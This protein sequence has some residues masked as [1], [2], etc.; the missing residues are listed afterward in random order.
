MPRDT[1]VPKIPLEEGPPLEV[2]RRILAIWFP[3]L[4]TDR[5]HRRLRAAAKSNQQD[6][7]NGA[8][9]PTNL[10]L[11]VSESGR[12]LVSAMDR[13]AAAEGIRLDMPLTDARALVPDIT[14]LPADLQ[15]DTRALAGLADWA[16]RYTPWA[17]PA[18][19][20]G[21][22]LD[23]SGCAHLFGG[24]MALCRDAAARLSGFGYGAR[25]AV[26]DTPGAAW[27]IARSGPAHVAGY[28]VAGYDVAG[29]EGGDDRGIL[30]PGR[31]RRALTGLSVEGLRL[32]PRTIA[33]L[34][35]LGLHRIGD[36]AGLPRG[37]VTKRFGEQVLLRL[38]QALG[39]VGEP[40]SPRLP[41]IPH[42]ARL[43][44]A[45]PIGRTEDVSAGLDRL[46]GQLCKG[47]EVAR[48][49]ARRL[50]LALYRVD[51]AVIRRSVG[52][53]RPVRAPVPLARL[54]T[55]KLDDIDAGFGIETMVLSAEATERLDLE[56]TDLDAREALRAAD[57]LAGLIDRAI[58]RF[59]P[60]SVTR[61]APRQSHLPERAVVSLPADAQLG[62]GLGV[63]AGKGNRDSYPGERWPAEWRRP[64]HLFAEP[65]PIE[66]IAPIPDDPPVLFRW[67]GVAH[68]IA[69]AEGPERIAPEWWLDGPGAPHSRPRDYYRVEDAAGRR[70][71]LFRHGL[72]DRADGVSSNS[73]ALPAWYLHGLFG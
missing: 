27:A 30:S 29:Q 40:I 26:A 47:L 3:S 13:A 67:R 33:D 4:P 62:Q 1:A 32:P 55:E 19:A 52:T 54:F 16:T 21:L 11:T 48:E 42:A 71:W 51:G 18:G 70:F 22:F 64:I 20:D 10:V 72:Y 31:G 58:G 15:A 36:L 57:A 49:G 73:A 34:R 12:L 61:L 65:Q 6:G 45:E 24:E 35:R 60:G 39:R 2:G 5:L 7:Q 8:D 68:P 53:V 66:A 46:L 56:Q 59:G 25:L 23:I 41:I 44:F 63:A 9:T 37:G 38:D 28:D 50:T 43:A 17:A 69:L 14:V